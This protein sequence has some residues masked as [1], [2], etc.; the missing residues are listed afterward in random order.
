MG[1]REAVLWSD[2]EAMKRLADHFG[3]LIATVPKS[4]PM[5][6]FMDLLKLD[7]RWS[8]WEMHGTLLGRGCRSGRQSKS[9]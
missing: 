8:M 2:A 3:L 9:S 7:A 4:F 5:Q 6:P 1:A